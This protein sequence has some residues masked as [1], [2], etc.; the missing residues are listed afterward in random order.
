MWTFIFAL[1]LSDMNDWSQLLVPH[2][3]P[4]DKL[5]SP[6]A[7]LKSFKLGL[8]TKCWIL[9]DISQI[10][11]EN[12]VGKLDGARHIHAEPERPWCPRDFEV[13]RE[14]E[15]KEREG[16][17]GILRA[18]EKDGVGQ[19]QAR[20]TTWKGI[21]TPTTKTGGW[22]RKTRGCENPNCVISTAEVWGDNYK[23]TPEGGAKPL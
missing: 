16:Q 6:Y 1:F 4:P 20:V 13:E 15:E 17:P 2:L 3:D 21:N 8:C 5:C 23:V 12:Q 18:T 22:Q 19:R 10:K 14:S 9:A 7:S 11:Q